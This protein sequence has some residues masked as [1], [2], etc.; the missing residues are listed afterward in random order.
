MAISAKE[1]ISRFDKGD[2]RH[3]D[4]CQCADCE[5]PIQETLTGNRHT[6]RG[7]VCSDCYFQDMGQWEA[8]HPIEPFDPSDADV[9]SES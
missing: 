8:A 5:K 4:E 1:F 6:E 3:G 7:R 9:M 2:I